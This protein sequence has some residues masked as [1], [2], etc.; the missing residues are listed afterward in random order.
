MHKPVEPGLDYAL[1]WSVANRWW[2]GGDGTGRTHTGS[3]GMFIAWAWYSP[4]KN[5]IMVVV[6][7]RAL[8]ADFA[9]VDS[10]FGPLFN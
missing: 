6:T 7:N 5:A 1:G 9:A 4:A 2:C 3:N 8:N 10:A